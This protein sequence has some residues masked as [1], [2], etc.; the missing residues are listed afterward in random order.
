[1]IRLLSLSIM[2]VAMLL[3]I[4]VHA[5]SSTPIP[6]DSIYQLNLPLVDQDGEKH[7]LSS[8]RGQ[9]R[10]I[11]MF[12]ASCP[13]MCPLIIDTA[14]MTERQL[15]PA[16]QG[17]LPVLLVSMDAKR[18]SPA[19][20][21]SLAEQRKIDTAH[22]MLAGTEASN[23][24]KLAAV[25]GIQ[26]RELDDGEFSHTSAL[27]LLDAE[28]RIIARTETMGKVDPEFV[29]AIRRVLSDPAA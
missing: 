11:S 19:A 9:P 26:Y 16:Q 22:W 2:L 18:D 7:S 20:L 21:K 27:I 25:L 28:G 29:D 17:N 12:Y 14:R 4:P 5:E 1:M 13:Y 3:C 8:L 15:D 23:V 24:R 10:I 6:G